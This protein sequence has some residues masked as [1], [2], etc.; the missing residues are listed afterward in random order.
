MAGRTLTYKEFWQLP[1]KER[2]ERYGELSDHDK[3]VIRCSMDTGCSTPA[4]NYCVH[5]KEHGCDAFPNGIPISV[6]NLKTDQKHDPEAL[7]ESCN[8]KD[9]IHFEP[10][11]SK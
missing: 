1:E 6:L 10:K 3:F 5:S 7:K 9:D 11:Q 8:G 4:C 2:A